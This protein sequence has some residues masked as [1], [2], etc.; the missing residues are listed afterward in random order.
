MRAVG[1]QLVQKL[2]P[3][4]HCLHVR[5]GHA[6]DVAARPVKAG[7]EAELEPGRRP[8]RRRSEWSWSP[9]SPQAPPEWSLRQS[10]PPDDEPDQPPLPAAD[11]FDPPPT[12]FDR[13]VLA[14]DVAGFA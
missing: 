12:V 11:Q 7:D 4:R 3:L 2:Q 8:F 13:H 9:P 14:I 5:L 10:R 6:G 1:K